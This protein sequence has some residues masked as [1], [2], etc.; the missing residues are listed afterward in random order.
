MKCRIDDAE[1]LLQDA[2][3]VWSELEEL[4]DKVEL[5]TSI[6]NLEQTIEKSEEEA[7]GLGALAK[8][9]KKGELTQLQQQ[10]QKLREK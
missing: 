10:V 6:H 7:K 8:M 2:S 1:S 5:Q 9:K 3:K 4:P